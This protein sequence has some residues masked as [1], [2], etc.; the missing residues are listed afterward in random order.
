MTDFYYETTGKNDDITVVVLSGRLDSTS[1]EYVF[2]CVENRVKDGSRKIVLDC[3]S[4]QYI[5]SM[6][7][8]MLLRVHSRLK[9]VDG[10]ANVAGVN[11]TVAKVIAMV[12]LDTVLHLYSTVDEAVAALEAE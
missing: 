5:S 4:L 9:K 8:G 3:T 1:A 7:L 12:R 2:S 10:D 11:S 6:G